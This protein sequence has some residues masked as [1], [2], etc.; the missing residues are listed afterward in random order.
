MKPLKPTAAPLL[1]LLGFLASSGCAHQVAFNEEDPSWHY[2]VET[3]TYDAGLVV[4]IDP[5]TLERTV[6][7]RSAM[8]GMAN[9]WDAQPG[10]MMKQ[11]ADFELPQMVEEYSSTT[12]FAEPSKGKRRVTVQLALEDYRFDDFAAH[13]RMRATAY[14][15]GK[16]LLFEKTY[17]ATG[18]SQGGK[19]FGGGAFG[20]KSAVRQSSLDAYKRIFA[21][22][23]QDLAPE[24]S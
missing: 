3:Q 21:S 11:V 22:L 4:V 24:L 2:R 6:S 20:M 14:G 8:A 12:T 19:M 5:A 17:S 10:R 1:I 15:P 16:T 7:I 23:R 9:R 18:D 13:V